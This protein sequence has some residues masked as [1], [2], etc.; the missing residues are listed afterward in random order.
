MAGSRSIVM[1][2]TVRRML[3]VAC[4]ISG[5]DLSHLVEIAEGVCEGGV[6]LG[7]ADIVAGRDR[8]GRCVAPNVPLLDLIDPNAV[9]FDSGVSTEDI[10][11]LHY[12]RHCLIGA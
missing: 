8:F 1:D 3:F 7:N 11:R 6:D 12:P 10:V 2:D 5:L 4:L 9:V